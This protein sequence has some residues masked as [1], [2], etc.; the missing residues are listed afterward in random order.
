KHLLALI[1]RKLLAS[2]TRA[3]AGTL[4]T[5]RARLE[6]LRDDALKPDSPL[7]LVDDVDD[8]YLQELLDEFE[9][10]DDELP[11]SDE[12]S[13]GVRTIDR[14][15]LVAEIDE[16]TRLADI[17]RGIPVDQKTKRLLDAL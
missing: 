3:V 16:I 5:L 1:G 14:Q 11:S 17:A 8:E 6:A 12:L 4:D 2:S 13:H 7:R 9:P 15:K 10:D